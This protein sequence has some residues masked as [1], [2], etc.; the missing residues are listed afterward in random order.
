MSSRE[1]SALVVPPFGWDKKSK[2]KKEVHPVFLEAKASEFEPLL[3]EQLVYCD[4]PR[5]LLNCKQ[6]FPVKRAHTF[7]FIGILWNHRDAMSLYCLLCSDMSDETDPTLIP[8]GACKGG[9]EHFPYVFAWKTCADSKTAYEYD[10]PENS[11]PDTPT[12]IQVQPYDS[13]CSLMEACRVDLFYWFLYAC[14]LNSI[15]HP[16]KLE[17]LHYYRK[18]QLEVAERG[19]PSFKRCIKAV[20]EKYTPSTG[21][22]SNVKLFFEETFPLL[23]KIKKM[24]N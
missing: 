9:Q 16:N 20:K 10:L 5:E 21:T 19:Q 12:Y 2:V 7:P 8:H 4:I 11:N 17:F 22:R 13:A 23:E 1:L 18:N 15:H 24:Y 3:P 6:I 14:L